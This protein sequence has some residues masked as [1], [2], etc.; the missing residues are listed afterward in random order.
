MMNTDKR[1]QIINSQKDEVFNKSILHG[2]STIIYE[3]GDW[4]FDPHLVDY[5]NDEMILF[6]TDGQELL[7]SYLGNDLAFDSLHEKSNGL[8]EVDKVRVSFNGLFV[9]E[10]QVQLSL[11]LMEE[12][13]EKTTYN[14]HLNS[15]IEIPN[16]TSNGG[17]LLLSLKG[18]G[19][20]YLVSIDLQPISFKNVK[21]QE[22]SAM[23][24]RV[25]NNVSEIS[26]ACV[27]DKKVKRFLGDHLALYDIDPLSW[28]SFLQ[29]H[30]P[31]L[32]LMDNYKLAQWACQLGS[33]L[34]LLK[35]IGQ[36]T[37]FCSE[38]DTLCVYLHLDFVDELNEM[39]KLAGV[40]FDKVIVIE[41]ASFLRTKNRYNLQSNKIK[42]P[43]MEKLRCKLRED[44]KLDG[45]LQFLTEVGIQVKNRN[46]V[47]VFSVVSS[48]EEFYKVLTMYK[49]Q[50]WSDKRLVVFV[51]PFIGYIELL[52]GYNEADVSVYLKDYAEEYYEI[53]HMVTGGYMA[54]FKGDSYYGINYLED[55]V[56][57]ARHTGYTVVGKASHGR[58]DNEL[59]YNNEDLQ[60]QLVDDLKTD[61]SLMDTCVL[62]DNSLKKL[63]SL[64]IEGKSVKDLF[65]SSSEDHK[66]FSIDKFNFIENLPFPYVIEEKNHTYFEHNANNVRK[67]KTNLLFAGHDLKFATKIIESFLGSDKYNVKI[68]QWSGHTGN[69]FL[70]SSS[71]LEWADVIVCEW[72]LGNVIWYSQRKRE[73]QRLIVRM[74][75]QEKFTNYHED[76]TLDNI[77]KFIVVSPWMFEE[78]HRILGIPRNKMVVIPNYVDC[79][80]LDKPKTENFNFNLGIIGMNPKLKRLDRALE[81]FEKL[82][83]KDKRFKLYLK[84]K[85]PSELKWLMQREHERVYYEQI[86]AKLDESQYK[87]NVI[88]EGY[89]NDIGDFLSKIG[90]VLSTSDHE[91][92]HLTVAE[93]MAAGSLPVILNWEGSQH[94]YPKDYIKSDTDAAVEFIAANAEKLGST[95]D[96]DLHVKDYSKQRFDV[97]LVCQLWQKVLE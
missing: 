86:F 52:Q 76:F 15:F 1:L 91:S 30:R 74:H 93:G 81:I 85:K 88:F 58:M 73:N 60:Y 77:E 42:L 34:E 14:V 13:H 24:E 32:V 50:S 62:K 18:K 46:D 87:D 65:F 38:N 44:N 96:G 69:D 22:M 35:L 55:L 33:E 57:N 6:N 27:L 66:F 64:Y 83:I 79:D 45:L 84:G 75:A 68:D 5:T 71:A 3:P 54:F 10:G 49:K 67:N 94:I 97:P 9:G 25:F 8:W 4:L 29:E 43:C 23:P 80:T 17:K 90:F 47:A 53:Q 82:W 21:T 11:V 72:G 48:E 89:G 12:N 61:R 16:P 2:S 95:L 39:K 28:E 63:L 92:F 70:L 7:V 19:E 31:N 59:V 41:K 40:L 20:F 78:F 51:E 26:V 56:L 37:N 36:I